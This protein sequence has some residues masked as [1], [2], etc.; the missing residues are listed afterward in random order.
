MQR[1]DAVRLIPLTLAGIGNLV[2]NTFAEQ[3]CSMCKDSGQMPGI[4]AMAYQQNVL[5]MLRWIR[6]SQSEK[7][8]ESAYAIA[9]T[10]R[11]GNTFWLNWDQG[12]G[13]NSEMYPGR[14]GMPL[15]CTHGYDPGKAKNGDLLM[16]SRIL[17]KEGFEDLAKKKDII[18]IGSPSPWSGDNH[19]F[20]NIREDIQPMK[21]RPYADIWIETNITSQGAIMKIPGMPAPIGPISGPLYMTL[22]W[23]VLADVCRIL[24]IEGKPV[25]VDGDEP[26]LSGDRVAWE[27]LADPLMD[28]YLE[29]IGR[30]MEL[31][32]AELGDVRKIA[33]MAVDTLLNGGTVYYYSRY[34]YTFATETT[35]RRGGFAFARALSDGKIDGTSKDCVIMGVYQP[36]DEVDLKNLREFKKRGMRVASIG[37]VTRDFQM[38]QGDCVHKEVEVHAGRMMDT[39]G[40]FAI[41]GFERKVCP[42]SGVLMFAINW[43]ISLEIIEQIR[44]RTGGNIPG[45]NLSGALKYGN[46]FNSRIRSMANDRGY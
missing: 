40:L 20:E 25:N 1:R 35:G 12:H 14:P 44:Q 38:P 46:G 8:L 31:I 36:D 30:E 34:S 24:S 6:E 17:S 9:R 42:T 45:V 33:S 3:S 41:P 23:M 26:K 15:F 39:Y 5:D 43:T 19:D 28:N 4:P 7:L 29:E 2:G 16:A 32:G 11:K 21:I 10:L 13:T 37:P 27:N 18:V 22:M